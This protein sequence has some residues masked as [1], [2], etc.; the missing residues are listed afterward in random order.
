[1]IQR[2]RVIVRQTPA[3]PVSTEDA[4]SAADDET[5]GDRILAAMK[6]GE[7]Y[8]PRQLVTVTGIRKAAA[9]LSRLAKRG[10]VRRKATSV[11]SDRNFIYRRVVH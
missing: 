1:M 3:T 5:N 10:L 9:Y 7:W 8:Q 2:T 6:A 4:T 11:T